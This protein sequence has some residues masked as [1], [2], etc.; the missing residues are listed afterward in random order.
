MKRQGHGKA[1]KGGP[2]WKERLFVGQDKVAM[3]G[4][5]TGCGWWLMRDC[6]GLTH[7]HAVVTKGEVKLTAS[8]QEALGAAVIRV[9]EI[10]STMEY[11]TIT[12]QSAQADELSQ[13]RHR[14]LK[15]VQATSG[16]W[17]HLDPQCVL[18][19]I[20][21]CASS[22]RSFPLLI[23]LASTWP[24]PEEAGAQGQAACRTEAHDHSD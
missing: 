16:A 5:N 13:Q 11:T 19:I 1:G 8:S 3:F 10:A 6:P 7:A 15:Q 24:R 18:H 12:V 20:G 23:D 22:L 4:A 2:Q 17:V 21:T 14:K 9:W